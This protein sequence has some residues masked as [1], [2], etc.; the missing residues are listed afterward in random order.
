MDGARAFWSGLGPRGQDRDEA[1]TRAAVNRSGSSF[2]LGMQSLS[3]ERRRA[4]HAVYAFCRAVDD[5]ADGAAPPAEKRRFLSQWRAEIDRLSR[6]P[7]TPVGRELARAA[8]AFD[9]PLAECHALLDGMETDAAERVRI[10]DD[11][12]FTLYARRVA[13]SVG[14]LSIH[15]FGTPEAQDFALRLGNTLQLVNILRDVDEDA[16]LE[17]VYVPLS[18]L[19][20]L[21][22]QDAPAATLVA[23]PR[24]ALACEALSE[25]AEQGFA[26]AD[27]ALETLDRSALRPAILM[28]EGYRRIHRRLRERGFGA[29]PGRVRLTSRDRLHLLSLSLRPA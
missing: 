2:R 29:R 3:Q 17:R 6:T 23:D 9:L 5:I 18:R 21:G 25:E 15:V 24:F 4:I 26:A 27:A 13:G 10:A 1:I 14:V 16:R 7:L 28:M 8:Q 12:A 11:A 19:A 22:L 20:A